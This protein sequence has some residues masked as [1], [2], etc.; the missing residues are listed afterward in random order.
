MKLI[1]RRLFLA[2]LASAP[3]AATAQN[4]P[5][6]KMGVSADITGGGAA[7][8]QMML[9]G[10]RA[11]AAYINAE[12]NYGFKIDIIAKD[13]R[14]QASDAISVANDMSAA[15]VPVVFGPFSSVQARGTQNVYQEHGVVQIVPAQADVLTNPAHRP[16]FFFRLNPKNG[17]LAAVMAQELLKA[18]NK[19]APKIAVLGDHTFFGHEYEAGIK[20]S[21]A[22]TTANIALAEHFTPDLRDFSVLGTKLK[23]IGADGVAFASV[24]PVQTGLFLKQ[25]RENSGWQGKV[26]LPGIGTLHNAVGHAFCAADGAIAVGGWNPA[27]TRSIDPVRQRYIANIVQAAGVEFRDVGP[28]AFA[29]VELVAQAAYASQSL[30]APDLAKTLQTASFSDTIYAAKGSIEFDGNGD[31]KTPHVQVYDWE[32]RST[33]AKCEV[34]ALKAR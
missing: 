26:V 2:G 18:V 34:P 20:Q 4:V 22:S 8:G 9:S 16:P 32:S 30:K 23:A 6:L 31:L 7:T 10:M 14:S 12:K 33:P 11:A 21:L 17:A 24:I 1:D 25:V 3:F 5:V 29:A 28:V 19:P 13:D 27:A 15:G